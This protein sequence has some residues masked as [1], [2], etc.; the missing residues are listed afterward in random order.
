MPTASVAMIALILPYGGQHPVRDAHAER[1]DERQEHR[2]AHADVLHRRGRDDPGQREDRPGREVQAAGDEDERP[3]AG[4][5]PDRRL[6]VGDVEQVA[7]REEDGAGERERHE[8][9]DEAS[10]I[11]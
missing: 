3:G 1:R 5:D 4:D 9:E 6:L 8:Q 11:P 10:T 2:R 7:R